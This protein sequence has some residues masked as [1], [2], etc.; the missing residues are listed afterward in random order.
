MPRI[1]I[2]TVLTL[3]VVGV[4]ALITFVSGLWVYVRATTTP[5]H[6]D[7]QKVPSALLS[8]PQPQ[9]STAVEAG[10]KIARDGLTDQNL[11]GMSVAV[12]VRGETI[13]AEGF[14]WADLEN[15]V[16]VTPHTRFRIGTQSA[17][18]TSAAV[19]LLLEK[20]QLKLDD[21]IQTY[22]PDFPKKQWP[23][24]LRQLMGHV[25][26]IVPDE[27]DE[28]DTTSHCER[29]ADGLKR[30]ADAKL[31]FEPGTRFRYSN[32]GWVLISAA[33]EKAAGEPFFTYVR[34]QVFNALGMEDTRHD[35]AGGATSDRAAQ[36]FPRFAAETR[37]GPQEPD[38]PDF[39]CF[40]GSS[41]FQSTPSDMVR[42]GM[43]IDRGRLL[44]PE[45]VKLLQTPQ[46]LASGE[47]TGY[48]L[49]W[50]LE[51]VQ[52]AGAERRLVVDDGSLRGGMVTSFI[53]FPERGIV[54]SV[55]SNTS[56]A[57][58]ASVALKLAEVFARAADK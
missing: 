22:V 2:Q 35:S 48:G 57:D 1:R 18:L 26:G 58:T 4:I 13:W 44:K 20:N 9:W 24:T 29:T 51:T 46:R 38:E 25:A 40:A 41:A 53:S 7:P 43:A 54:V 27:G 5:I 32:W 50:D 21:E 14:G 37:Y 3:F 16:R 30:F 36:Y 19:G 55:M 12:G 33:T 15:Q 11:P 39:S 34:E 8:A 47:D 31:L 42:F 23:V 17:M 56:Y 6:A 49:G 45:T 28:E 52:L 10:R